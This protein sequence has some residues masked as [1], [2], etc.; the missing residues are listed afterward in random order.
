LTASVQNISSIQEVSITLIKNAVLVVVSHTI[1]AMST[2]ILHPKKV[3]VLKL[4]MIIFNKKKKKTLIIVYCYYQVL[5]R[6]I[7]HMNLH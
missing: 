4:Y 3:N 6:L 7:H 5:Q 2:V 1:A